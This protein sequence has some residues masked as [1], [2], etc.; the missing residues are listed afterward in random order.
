MSVSSQETPKRM[1]WPERLQEIEGNRFST[2]EKVVD[3]KPPNGSMG[4]YVGVIK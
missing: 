2:V 3:R 1:L 4:G